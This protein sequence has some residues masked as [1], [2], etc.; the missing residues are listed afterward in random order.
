MSN[1][2]VQCFHCNGKQLPKSNEFL[3]SMHSWR[4]RMRD[5]M[6]AHPSSFLE[7]IQM[8]REQRQQ[9]VPHHFCSLLCFCDHGC[10][11]GT[12]RMTVDDDGRLN[13]MI[14]IVESI[15]CIV[16]DAIFPGCPVGRSVS[17][18]IER[19]ELMADR[20]GARNRHK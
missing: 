7:T 3:D 8:T 14:E 18:E 10:H 15:F 20:K 5:R 12:Q 9:A 6:R 13:V 19:M 16:H 17:S 2:S 1:N 11:H 4:D